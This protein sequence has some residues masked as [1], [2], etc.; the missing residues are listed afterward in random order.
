MTAGLASAVLGMQVAHIGQ[1]TQ[2][3]SCWSVQPDCS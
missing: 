1:L 3:V 2:L